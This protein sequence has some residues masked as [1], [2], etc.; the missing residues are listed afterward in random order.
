MLKCTDYRG[1]ILAHTENRC[2]YDHTY[3]T[4]ASCFLYPGS[5]LVSAPPLVLVPLPAAP[6]DEDNDASVDTSPE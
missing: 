6:A 4:G 2:I 3:R 1:H 5:P